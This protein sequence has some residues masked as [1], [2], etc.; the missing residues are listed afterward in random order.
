MSV[1][2][3]PRSIGFASQR[4]STFCHASRAILKLFSHA[5]CCRRDLLRM[6]RWEYP[7]IVYCIGWVHSRQSGMRKW[8]PFLVGRVPS[9]VSFRLTPWISEFR[10][11]LLII[12]HVQECSDDGLIALQH[13]DCWLTKDVVSFA[14]V[15]NL[16]LNPVMCSLGELD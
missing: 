2:R 4:S 3:G 12:E 5:C 8:F 10:V 7:K 15:Y 11:V 1:W 14:L 9:C 13:C 16:R 6:I